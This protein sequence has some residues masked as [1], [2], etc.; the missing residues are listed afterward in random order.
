MIKRVRSLIRSQEEDVM[1]TGRIF[2][3]GVGVVGCGQNCMCMRK[4]MFTINN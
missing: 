1:P 3:R 2:S 4:L